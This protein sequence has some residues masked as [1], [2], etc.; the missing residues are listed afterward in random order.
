MIL[1]YQ[2]IES[3]IVQIIS[4]FEVVLKI[5]LLKIKPLNPDVKILFMENQQLIIH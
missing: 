5:F 2:E 1:G 4:K 3:L